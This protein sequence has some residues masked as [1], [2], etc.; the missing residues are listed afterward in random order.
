MRPD[1]T[2]NVISDVVYTFKSES[3][4]RVGFQ[5]FLIQGGGNVPEIQPSVGS[6]LQGECLQKQ[7]RRASPG[8]SVTAW[9][10]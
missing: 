5:S 8:I 1:R 3:V 4:E 6:A 10:G 9:K 2:V 7:K